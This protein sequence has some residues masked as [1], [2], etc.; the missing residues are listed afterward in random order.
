MIVFVSHF[1]SLSLSLYVFL[2]LCPSVSLLRSLFFLLILL[3]SFLLTFLQ[4]FARAAAHGQ[5][6]LVMRMCILCAI[7]EGCYCSLRTQKADTGQCRGNSRSQRILNTAMGEKMRE[8]ERGRGRG[9]ER[10]RQRK[11]ETGRG[12][13]RENNSR[14][15]NPLILWNNRVGLVA[16]V[17]YALAQNT[18]K[19]SESL[20][21][22]CFLSLYFSFYV[23]LSLPILTHFLSHMQRYV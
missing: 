19:N 13:G 9:R 8:R 1:T 11:T 2:C 5:F 10:E 18:W 15:S 21:L 7:P 22:S 23:S 17:C 12:R 14:Q 3:L 6:L 20:S 4:L 16:P